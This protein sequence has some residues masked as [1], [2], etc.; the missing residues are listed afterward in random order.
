MTQTASTLLAVLSAPV[1]AMA[2]TFAITDGRGVPS[3]SKMLAAGFAIVIGRDVW[4]HGATVS[5]VVAMGLV[6]SVAFGRAMYSK[7]LDR[8]TWTGVSTAATSATLSTTLTG[9]LAQ[10]AKTVTSR[11]GSGDTESTG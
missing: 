4:L 7:W 1:R 11:R 2:W 10:L 6:C 9:D 8:N 3:L 5:N